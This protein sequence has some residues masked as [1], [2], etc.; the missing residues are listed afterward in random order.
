MFAWRCESNKKLDEKLRK[1][2][3]DLLT[4]DK[5]YRNSE[6]IITLTVAALGNVSAVFLE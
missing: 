4:V 5:I 3:S 2:K 1:N 6:T